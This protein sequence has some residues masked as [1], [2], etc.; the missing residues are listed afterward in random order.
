VTRRAK[1]TT[2]PIVLIGLFLSLS[3][4]PSDENTPGAAVKTFYDHLNDGRNSEAMAM[5]DDEA[6][7]MFEDP[8]FASEGA[9]DEWVA[10]ETKQGSIREVEIVDA[11]TEEA[12]AEVK[13]R[14]EYEDGSSKTG[15]V[16]L[17]L[18]QGRWKLGL[19]H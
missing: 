14:V 4:A 3:C 1:S 5:Y 6:S 10:S 7:G 8:S 11:S 15:E 12:S 2:L 9:F 16:S 19:I 18:E 13:F 17:S